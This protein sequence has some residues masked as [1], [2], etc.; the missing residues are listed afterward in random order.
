LCSTTDIAT[1]DESNS[2]MTESNHRYLTREQSAEFLTDN[3][4]PITHRYFVTLCTRGDGPDPDRWWG[5]RALYSEP[6][7]LEW[8]EARVRPGH[9]RPFEGKRPGAGR[10]HK[11]DENRPNRAA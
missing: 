9:E 7:L 3:G 4:F 1:H 6:R 2:L 8:A 11:S 5:R 10:P